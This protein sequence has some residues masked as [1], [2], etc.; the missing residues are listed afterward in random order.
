MHIGRRWA[1]LMP[2]REFRWPRRQRTVTMTAIRL[3]KTSATP[4]RE[5]S[6]QATE[7]SMIKEDMCRMEGLSWRKRLLMSREVVRHNEA[8]G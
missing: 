3:M 7:V 1:P 4:R 5:S 8:E 2:R 6:G